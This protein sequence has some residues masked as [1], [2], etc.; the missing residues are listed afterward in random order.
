MKKV[1]RMTEADLTKLVKRVIQ[2]QATEKLIQSVPSKQSVGK[3]TDTVSKPAP[4]QSDGKLIST[5]SK[6]DSDSWF[7]SF[8]CL[9][10][11]EKSKRPMVNGN[12]V[13]KTNASGTPYILLPES[14]RDDSQYSFAIK[15]NPVNRYVGQIKGGGVYYCSSESWAKGFGP[16]IAKLN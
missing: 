10:D 8:P 4:K 15:Q 16:Q 12:I 3:I 5:V 9:N 11:V 13:L 2:E 14:G 1:I 6:T 7:S